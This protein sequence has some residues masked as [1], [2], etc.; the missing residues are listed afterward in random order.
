[1]TLNMEVLKTAFL[2]TVNKLLGNSSSYLNILSENLETAIKKNNSVESLD[3]RISKLQIEL[4]DR[5]NRHENY[6]ELAE[7]I[8]RLREIREQTAMAD[9]EKTEYKK[10]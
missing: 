9:T 4:I 2:D 6:D 7:E 8:L 5:T 1:M 3:E 10:N